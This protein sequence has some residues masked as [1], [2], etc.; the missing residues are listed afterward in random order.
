MNMKGIG[1]YF[2][3]PPKYARNN[4]LQMIKNKKITFSNVKNLDQAKFH[5][6]QIK[7]AIEEML[8]L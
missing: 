4:F 7:S 6:E 8:S 3:V 1:S 2:Q 5:D